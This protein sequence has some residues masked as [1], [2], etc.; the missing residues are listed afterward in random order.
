[1]KTSA[2]MLAGLLAGL[3][4]GG[5]SQAQSVSDPAIIVPASRSKKKSDDNANPLRGLSPKV[6]RCVVNCQEPSFQCA[7]RC[8]REATHTCMEKCSTQMFSCMEKCGV[9]TKKLQEPG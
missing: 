7:R 5:V 9:D 8:G 3:A 1:M 4:L 6:A 2:A